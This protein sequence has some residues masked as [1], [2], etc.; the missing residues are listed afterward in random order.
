MRVDNHS[1]IILA[2][3]QE[4]VAAAR[5]HKIDR[6]SITEHVSQFRP[7]RESVDFGSVHRQ[8]RMFESLR[9]YRAEF[10][11]VPESALSGMKLRM[12]LEV[13]FSPRY[14]AKV[15]EFVNQEKWD[16]L[17]C[18]VHELADGA[19]V[20]GTRQ[21]ATDRA[22]AARLWHEYFRLQQL[23][24]ESDFVPFAVLT[25]PTRLAKGISRLPEDLDDLLLN[26]A[27]T[28]NRR[29]KALELNGNDLGYAPELVRKVANACASAGCSVSLGSDSHLPQ[30]V[31]RKMKEATALVE[32]FSLQPV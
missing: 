1:H 24:L 6:Y 7:M 25:H 32:E 5:K 28:A 30:E 15:G 26:L 14:E 2:D 12:G 21:R 31:F 11:K 9:E 20:E 19:E 18:S 22:E 4:M 10:S 3:I 16:I 29:G 13:D 8:G 23:A 27:K 17:L